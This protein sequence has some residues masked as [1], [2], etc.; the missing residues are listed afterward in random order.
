[1]LLMGDEMGRT[2]LGNNNAY[3]QDNET[4]WLN[5][6]LLETEN[7]LW[8]F[9]Q[10]CIAFRQVHTV[11]RNGDYISSGPGTTGG[12]P[13][14][15]W[16]GKRAWEADWSHDSR[17]LAFMLC[18]RDPNAA[19]VDDVLFVAMN[20]YWETLEYDLPTPP[21][22]IRWCVFA[23]TAE[24]PPADICRPGQEQ[25]L[26]DQGK[27]HLGERSVV[28]LVGRPDEPDQRE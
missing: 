13:A 14:I 7:E 22:G 12:F 4:N 16:H 19:L 9:V 23:N 20:M 6:S 21:E 27:L 28:I 8:G 3:C 2:Q 10:N 26:S 11:L 1:M 25:P 18:G 5:W 15:S 24:H 17:S